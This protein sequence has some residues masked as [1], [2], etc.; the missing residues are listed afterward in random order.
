MY[1]FYWFLKCFGDSIWEI[2][3]YLGGFNSN[4]EL[5]FVGRLGANWVF[6]TGLS[7]F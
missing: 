4:S 1:L 6:E 5:Y 7:F 3:T 2:A